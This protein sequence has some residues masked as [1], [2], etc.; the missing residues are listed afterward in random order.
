M[1][2]KAFD[3]GEVWNPVGWHGN[4]TVKLLLS[5]TIS[6]ILLQRIKHFRYKLAEISPFIIFEQNLVECL[7][8][9]VG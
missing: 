9:S 6:R 5:S 4:R 2:R 8:S 3:M 7:M 1:A